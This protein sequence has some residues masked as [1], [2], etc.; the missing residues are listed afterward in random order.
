[1]PPRRLIHS[2]V[3]DPEREGER[4]WVFSSW[5]WPLALYCVDS[6][7]INMVKWAQNDPGPRA[8]G[9]SVSK[10]IWNTDQMTGTQ[11]SLVP[12]EGVSWQPGSCTR[13]SWLLKP[14]KACQSM[15]NARHVYNRVSRFYPSHTPL[16]LFFLICCWVTKLCSS[17]LHYI[18]EFAPIQVH[19]VRDAI[20][21]S[22]PSHPSGVGI[23]ITL[24]FQLRKVRQSTI[25]LSIFCS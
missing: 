1:M 11:Q 25:S 14:R 18:L 13:P 2:T 6:A 3:K 5:V 22:H 15:L 7:E 9:A 23:N 10:C 4:P 12:S 17:V 21:T 19:W 20:W 24:I 16:S 8:L